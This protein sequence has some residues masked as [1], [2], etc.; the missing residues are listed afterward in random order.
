MLA[1]EAFI[2]DEIID[3]LYVFEVIETSTFFISVTLIWAFRICT[4]V[5]GWKKINSNELLK[6]LKNERLNSITSLVH[7]NISKYQNL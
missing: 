4:R 6:L 1:L 7:R 5:V 3:S 2:E